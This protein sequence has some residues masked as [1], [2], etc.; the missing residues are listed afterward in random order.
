[1]FFGLTSPCTSARLVASVVCGQL[2]QAPAPDRDARG[3][4]RPDKAPAGWR[5]RCRRWRNAAAISGAAGG[6]GVDGGQPLADRDCGLFAQ[7]AIAQL[8]LPV[9]VERRREILHHEQSGIAVLRDEVWHRAGPDRLR[10]G[11]P[12][13]FG[14]VALD[15]RFPDRRDLE[16]GERA[17]HTVC[18]RSDLHPP[19]IGGNAAVERHADRRLVR[20]EQAHTAEHGAD[21]W[22]GQ[23]IAARKRA[24]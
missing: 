17:F 3:R 15:W 11:E 6:G 14:I 1:M 16:L 7:Q 20:R 9:R 4:W 19:D 13:P 22:F 10:R 18:P 5:G 2:A 24:A 23:R 8:A 12:L 21:L